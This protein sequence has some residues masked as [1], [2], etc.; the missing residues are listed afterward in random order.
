MKSNEPMKLVFTSFR[1]SMTM[2]GM[3]MSIDKHTPKLCAYPT[4]TYLVVPTASKSISKENMERIC[5]T[6]LD[7]NWT[8]IRDFIVEAYEN[9]GVRQIILC[10]WATAEQI[11]TGKPCMAGVIAR[12]IEREV[13]N[14]EF[15]FPME[16][17][18]RDGREV[19]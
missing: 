12:Y 14:L 11:A 19:L 9:L 8:L 6:I 17:E 3:K 4:L 1:D 16:I 15:T 7:N 10:D 13:K 18:M 5:E 2:E